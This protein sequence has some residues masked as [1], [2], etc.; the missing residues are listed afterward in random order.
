[1]RFKTVV[2]AEIYIS[3]QNKKYVKEA[4]KEIVKEIE[5]ASIGN[6]SIRVE[7]LKIEIE[8]LAF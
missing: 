4:I 3:A 2:K 6:Y 7:K 1:M 8:K 5:I